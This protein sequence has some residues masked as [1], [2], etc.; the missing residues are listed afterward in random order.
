MMAARPR[1]SPLHR[2]EEVTVNYYYF[3]DLSSTYLL[4][5]EIDCLL[6]SQLEGLRYSHN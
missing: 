6:S 5:L 2:L 3:P 1:P 4:S